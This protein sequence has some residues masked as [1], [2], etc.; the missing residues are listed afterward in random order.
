MTLA[1][2]LG[3]ATTRR[4]LDTPEIH[5][6]MDEMSCEARRI[7]FELNSAYH[8]PDEGF[9]ACQAFE[10]VELEERPLTELHIVRS[11]HEA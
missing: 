11:G 3:Y 4:P 10:Y 9:V 2:F 8:T 6:F 7:T 1:E 5:R